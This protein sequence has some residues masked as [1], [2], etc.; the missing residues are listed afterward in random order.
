[1][2]IS[3]FQH[4]RGSSS[5]LAAYFYLFI[6]F[7]FEF[8]NIKKCSLSQL[9]E[10]Q[11]S[12]KFQVQTQQTC[13]PDTFRFEMLLFLFPFLHTVCSL[14]ALHFNMSFPARQIWLFVS[15]YVSEWQY[16]W[17]V[18]CC[19]KLRPLKGR[20]NSGV[21]VSAAMAAVHFS[22][23]L[24]SEKPVTLL[25]INASVRWAVS[26]LQQPLNPD[27]RCSLSPTTS[28]LQP[29]P[30]LQRNKSMA[31]FPH[32][33]SATTANA[34]KSLLS[35]MGGNAHVR[36]QVRPRRQSDGIGIITEATCVAGKLRLRL[37]D[38]VMSCDGGGVLGWLWLLSACGQPDIWTR[39]NLWW[40]DE[41]N[42]IPSVQQGSP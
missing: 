35:N 30:V 26:E 1:M 2:G 28:G 27:S 4:K 38:R 11:V 15:S 16:V 9:S 8:L 20:K 36:W 23:E 21:F 32:S 34:K 42:L 37:R 29:Q 12:K 19:C 25:M 39:C 40:S 33:A 10:R 31:A 7:F 5:C 17:L 3:L 13:V 14:E 6:F 22:P 41:A 18:S 24:L